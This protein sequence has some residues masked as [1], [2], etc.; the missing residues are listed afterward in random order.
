MNIID[1]G[2]FMALTDSLVAVDVRALE[3]FTRLD[4][5]DR[6]NKL[7]ESSK[8]DACVIERIKSG[9][10]YVYAL[11]E[12]SGCDIDE[13]RI[14]MLFC[15][16]ANNI[17]PAFASSDYL[18]SLPWKDMTPSSPKWVSD[19][20]HVQCGTVGLLCMESVRRCAK[21]YGLTPDSSE[22]FS[23]F[24]RGWANTMCQ[25]TT[26]STKIGLSNLPGGPIGVISS[27]GI[28]DTGRYNCKIT[29]DDYTGEVSGIKMMFPSQ[30]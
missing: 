22:P 1:G 11:T 10:W 5:L 25:I 6:C 17:D 9:L 27:V 29:H 26:T 2:C 16:S 15:I 23:Q 14:A 19:D 21:H 7:E 8:V 20:I 30:N 3:E 4:M 18:L 24:I 12:S 13:N 28:C